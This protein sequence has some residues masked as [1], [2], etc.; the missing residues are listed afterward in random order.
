MRRLLLL[1]LL[2]LP[3]LADVPPS[4]TA[5]CGGKQESDACETDAKT[6]GSCVKSTCSKNDYSQGVPPKSVTYECLKC[7]SSAAAPAPAPAPVE[8]PKKE[9]KKSSCAAMPADAVMGLGALLL[10]R[11]RRR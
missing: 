9:E 4:D 5:G 2:A 6:A 3:A 7:V 1:T 11:R 10:L 8:T